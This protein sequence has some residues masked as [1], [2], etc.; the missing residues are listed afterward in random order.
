MEE[1]LADK[2]NQVLSR[3]EKNRES[4]IPIIQEIQAAFGYLPREALLKV[5]EHLRLPASTVYGVATF[6]AQFSLIRQGEHKV[7]VCQGTACHVRGGRHVM[8]AMK[9]ELGIEPGETTPDYK[10]SLARVACV[11]SCS[12]APVVVVDE[13]VYGC[14]T[15]NKVRELTRNVP[16]KLRKRRRVFRIK[17][18]F[19]VPA[20]HSIWSKQTPARC[21]KASPESPPP[22]TAGQKHVIGGCLYAED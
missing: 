21:G 1:G 19:K 22:V 5:A 14:M 10:F 8:E 16:K 20:A 6:Y 17:V 3:Y 18:V 7:R 13:K 15:A 4:L 12:L 11:G 2:L 9:E